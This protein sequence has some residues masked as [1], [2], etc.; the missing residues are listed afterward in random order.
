MNRFRDQK[1]I[2]I[3]DDKAWQLDADL[4]GG[5][6][7]LHSY[8]APPSGAYLAPREDRG[9]AYDPHGAYAAGHLLLRATLG[10]RC[11]DWRFYR[12][13]LDARNG[14]STGSEDDGED[15]LVRAH[16]SSSQDSLAIVPWSPVLEDEGTEGL[17]L[18]QA[19]PSADVAADRVVLALVKAA[20]S[21]S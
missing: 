15:V 2:R 3:E 8:L 7:T 9:T 6:A 14:A 12:V 11:A 1:A 20:E 18:A 21:A 17:S 10:A 5:P 16:A 13:G 19:L 4:E